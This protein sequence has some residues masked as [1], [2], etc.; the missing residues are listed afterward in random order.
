MY[1]Y[2]NKLVFPIYISDQKF[3]Y[4]IHL[5]FVIDENKSHYVYI[6][7]FNKFMFHKNLQCFSSKN[8]LT[9]HKEV[10]LSINGAQSV[11]LEKGTVE[12][13]NH[14]K[15]IA[16]TF[17]VYVDFD[18]NLESVESYKG[19]YSKNIKIIFLV[20]LLRSLFV[21]MINLSNQ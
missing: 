3:E 2:E 9:E 11:R 4:S 1:C 16:V 6:K 5:L 19:F 13:K 12:F 14:F 7:D 15:Q 8:V 18:C 10:S 17:K 20:V 21:L